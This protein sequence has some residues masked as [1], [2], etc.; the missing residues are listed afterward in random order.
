MAAQELKKCENCYF[1]DGAWCKKNRCV[2]SIYGCRHHMTEEE[3]K[4]K[5]KEEMDRQ[6]MEYERKMNFILTILVNAA[7]ATQI[8]MEQF[9]KMIVDKNAEKQWR[10]ERKK[11]FNDIRAC[12]E[13]MR[14]LYERYIQPDIVGSMKTEE[15]KFDVTKYDDNQRDANELVRLMLWHWETCFA[16]FENVDK[17]FGFYQSLK[18]AGIFTKYEIEKFKI[19]R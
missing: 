3:L 5:I 8:V 18:G 19:D 13:K 9:D 12:A 1:A 17:V 15:G 2:H 14:S 6:E 11:A 4:Q 7:S 10:Q 16:S